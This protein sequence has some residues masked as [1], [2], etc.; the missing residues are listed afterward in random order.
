MQNQLIIDVLIPAFNEEKSIG[1]V[2][3]DIPSYVRNVVVVNNGSTDDTVETAKAYGAIVLDEPIKGYGRACLRGIDY[4]KQINTP[5]DVLVFLDGDYS[6]YPEQMDRLI[7][8]IVEGMDMVLGSRELGN[9]NRGS[10]TLPQIFGN[11][12]ATFLM[13]KIYG[14]KFTDLGP[15]RAVVWEKLM[16]LNMQ[17]QNYGWTI[18]MQ[19]KAVKQGMRVKEVPV[20]YRQRIGVSK[21]SGTIKGVIGAGYKI[22]FT[23]WKYR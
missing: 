12:L 1:K 2:I 15:F 4:L 11:A 9:R 10:M 3:N 17:D 19:I 7:E 8:K 5:P 13:H 23:I 21:V 14:Y 20:D 22:L 6:D 16:R 18:E